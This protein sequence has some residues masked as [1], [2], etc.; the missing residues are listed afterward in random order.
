M[1]KLI[2]LIQ[3]SFY[4][5]IGGVH[6]AEWSGLEA[7]FILS[8]PY[9]DGKS[10]QWICADRTEFQRYMEKYGVTVDRKSIYID[11]GVLW[12][13]GKDKRMAGIVSN[14]WSESSLRSRN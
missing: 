5:D 3:C 1:S 4:C 13:P 12:M 2:L 14:M 8:E 9:Y 7:E 11:L 6:Y 10:G